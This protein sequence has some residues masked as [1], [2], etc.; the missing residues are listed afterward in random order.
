MFII[1]DLGLWY[2][3][4]PME[5]AENFEQKIN[6]N[7]VGSLVDLNFSI[8][9]LKRRID[10]ATGKKKVD[11]VVK[12]ASIVNVFSGE[13]HKSD[14]AIADGIFVGFGETEEFREYDAQNVIDVQGRFMCPGLIDGHIH[15][16][17]TFLDP[18]QFCNVV[19]L[20][21]TSAVICDPHE[22]A[23]VL[24]LRGIDYFLQ[25][26]IGL[27]VKVYV[28]MPSCVPATRM[29]TSGAV[30]LDKDIQEYMDC[31]PDFVIGLA[32]M[33][34]YPGVISKDNE[35]LSKLIAAGPRPKD[36]HAPLL[37]GKSLDAYVIAGLGSDHECTNLKEAREKL[38]KSMHIMIRQ[39]A[40]EKNL[41]D[42]IPLINNF[43]SSYI[44]LVSDDR[45]VI[46]LKE[47]GHMDYLVRTAI[48]LGLPPLRAIQMASI[49]TA[50]YFGL[51]NLGAI[52]PGFRADF[53]LVD[54]LE[55][56]RVSQVFL[57]G[58]RINTSISGSGNVGGKIKK[59][60]HILVNN[61]NSSSSI[62]QNTMHIKTFEDLNMFTIPAKSTTSS[63][64][65]VIGVVP[66]QI[67]TQKRIIQAKVDYDHMAVADAQ[68]DLAKLAVIE[69]HD[70]TG[71][72]GLGFVQGLG[73]EKGAI[74]SSVAH[75]SHNLVV[76]GMNDMDMIVAARH[77][78]SIGGGLAVAYDEQIT[79]SLPLPIAGLM[80]DQTIESVI[81]KLKSVNKASIKL[82]S[83]VIKDPFMLLSF[84]SL[85]VIPSLK[86]TDKG[87]VD[88]DKFQL[89][90]LWVVDNQ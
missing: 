67:I 38:R 19:A 45:D 7:I 52:A 44:S 74:A 48:S 28:M 42:L 84:L 35:T 83:N 20:H 33:M 11:L 31:N 41:Q 16:E 81:S 36:G 54:N 4:Y 22:I 8:A 78:S 30:I 70:R 86:L 29:E 5:H 47:N 73:L 14:V 64:L 87:L 23:N 82:G 58:K 75:D 32:E 76:A 24:G 80:S 25:S 43:N 77:I 37:S 57:D 18:R 90:N 88:V 63:L 6:T 65:Q 50:R 79:A 26:S 9:G 2:C 12:N 13:I 3:L 69:R 61:N 59:G 21:G 55:S 60:T 51:K 85:P 46:D 17:S 62:L 34:N 49:N 56:F 66:G 39:G 27:P 10:L 68:R 53:I 40:H 71:N 1:L 15:L 89:T 72:V